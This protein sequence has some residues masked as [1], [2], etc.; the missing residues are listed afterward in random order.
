MCGGEIKKE[1]KKRNVWMKKIKRKM[2]N[3]IK[4]KKSKLRNVTII[5]S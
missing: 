4:N 1:K 3:K 5:F 2:K